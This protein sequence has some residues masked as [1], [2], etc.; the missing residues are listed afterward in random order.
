MLTLGHPW[1]VADRYTAHWP[2]VIPGGLAELVG[3]RGDFLGTALV[4]PGARLV[5]RLLARYQSIDLTRVWFEQRLEA[6]RIA[7][8]WLDLGD[9]TTWRLVNGEG[10]GLPGLS[11]DRYG[12]FLLVQ[13]YTPAW[14]AH[15]DTLSQALCATFSPR[16]IYVKFRPQETRRL[17]VE[18]QARGRLLCGVPAPAEFWVREHGLDYRVDLERDMH[19]GLFLDQR[20]NRR[21]LRRLAAGGRVLNLFAYTGAFS[22]AAAVGGA[23]QVTSVDIAERYLDRARDNFCRNGIDPADHEFITG[24]CFAELERLGAAGRCFDLICMDP[25]SFSTTR[26]SRFTTSGGTAELV[27]L[28]LGL[29]PRGG[30]LVT[31]SNLHKMTL[32]DYLKELRKGCARVARS[33][34]VIEVSGQ[35][36]DFPFI[37][38]FPEGRY[39]KYLVSVVQD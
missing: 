27:Q 25:P 4:D 11:V 20:D 17:E 3:V 26:K 9:T 24:D 6:A 34:Q 19:T 5:A 39:L 31:S 35:G 22:V 36:A 13:Y 1:V 28:A 21:R 14:Q 33:L 10:D 29:L 15:L 8:Q 12:D 7:R 16:G 37:V 38:G 23:L 32:E 30:L 18:H 2:K